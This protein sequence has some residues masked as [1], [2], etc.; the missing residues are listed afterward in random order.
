[1]IRNLVP[2]GSPAVFRRKCM[3]CSINYPAQK[4]P[5]VFDSIVNDHPDFWKQFASVVFRQLVQSTLRPG[6]GFGVLGA[7]D[8]SFSHG[9]I[10]VRSTDLIQYQKAQRRSEPSAARLCEADDAFQL[11]DGCSLHSATCLRHQKI[12]DCCMGCITQLA[13]IDRQF[14]YLACCAFNGPTSICPKTHTLHRNP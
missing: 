5:M 14:L 2:E 1:M 11:A 10:M 6:F 13:N 9:Y 4:Q 7:L 8:D 12:C 3:Y